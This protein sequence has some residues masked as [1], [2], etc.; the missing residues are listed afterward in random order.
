LGTLAKSGKKLRFLPL[1]LA[2][3]ADGLLL[4]EFFGDGTQGGIL[5]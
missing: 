4:A 1:E 5:S 3:V 2:Q